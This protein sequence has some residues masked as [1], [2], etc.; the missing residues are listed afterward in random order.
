MDQKKVISDLKKQYPGKA[1]IAN[2]SKN[3]TEIICEIDPGSLHPQYSSLIYVI[4]QTKPHYHERS[5][6]IYYVLK[7]KLELFVEGARYTLTEDQ[8]RVIPPGKIHFAKGKA[9]WVLVYSEPGWQKQDHLE[10]KEK[11][12]EFLPTLTHV[13]LL[14]EDYSRMFNFY[15]QTLGLTVAWGKPDGNYAEFETGEARIAI[16]RQEKMPKIIQ[17][18][19]SKNKPISLINMQ[20]EDLKSAVAFLQEKKLSFLV[21]ATR[22]PEAGIESCYL[23]DP[24]GNI[25]EIY[26]DLE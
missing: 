26:S 2:D 14:V 22:Y 23:E 1:I 5:A 17:D 16:Y 13:R 3:A 6:E 12:S 25:L 8:Y 15:Q 4:D 18:K 11:P 21:P 20:V 19:L 7:G 9:T 24:E 10:V